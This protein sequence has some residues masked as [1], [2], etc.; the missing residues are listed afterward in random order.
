[1]NPAATTMS[2]ERFADQVERIYVTHIALGDGS[3][4]GCLTFW[5]RWV[6][7]P[8]TQAE[9]AAASRKR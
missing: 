1:M 7:H 2:H 6:P 5:H 3:C 4:A 9:W 8:C